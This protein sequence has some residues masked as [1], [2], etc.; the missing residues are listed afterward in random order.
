MSSMLQ[1][2][3]LV[4]KYADLHGEMQRA[5]GEYIED[6]K[7]RRYPAQEHTVDMP[8]EEWQMLLGEITAEKLK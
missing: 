8:E 5:F 4:K 6:V 2:S 1:A 3:H 7:A